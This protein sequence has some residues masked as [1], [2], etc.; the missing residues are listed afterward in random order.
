[1]AALCNAQICTPPVYN[2][3]S[4]DKLVFIISIRLNVAKVCTYLKKSGL[5]ITWLKISL[6]RN[7]SSAGIT[8]TSASEIGR[9]SCR[10]RV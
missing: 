5:K 4:C 3:N 9:A 8:A 2:H 6:A 1:M 10:E 7:F